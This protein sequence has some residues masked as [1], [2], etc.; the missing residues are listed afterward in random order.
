MT[1]IISYL[2]INTIIINYNKEQIY[3]IIVIELLLYFY[4]HTNLNTSLQ[5][6]NIYEY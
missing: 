5:F 1:V 3:K 2:H 6:L 4:F